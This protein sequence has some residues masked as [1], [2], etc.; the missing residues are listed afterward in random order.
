MRKLILHLLIAFV[1]IP[2]FAEGISQQ[3]I[4]KTALESTV[5]VVVNDENGKPLQ[6]GSGFVIDDGKIVT[7]F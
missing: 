3:D 2:T 1:S 6:L 5:M 4:A 7:S